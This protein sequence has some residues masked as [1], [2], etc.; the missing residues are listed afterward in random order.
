M[1][2]WLH[3]LY[4]QAKNI[5]KTNPKVFIANVN[6]TN[7][8]EV[9]LIFATAASEYRDLSMERKKGVTTTSLI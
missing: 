1:H 8:T 9:A 3:C 4:R 6:K 7:L 5:C 2:F